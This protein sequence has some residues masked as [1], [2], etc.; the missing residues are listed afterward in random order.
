MVALTR[1]L[2]EAADQITILSGGKGKSHGATTEELVSYYAL[3]GISAEVLRFEA[4]KPG[5]ALLE[6]TR[7]VG[8][9]LLMM[10]AY[11]VSHERE[12]LF[13]GNTQAVVDHA[14]LP[15]VLAH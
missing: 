5:A 2:A 15:A 12:T 4:N 13:G 7:E 1:D 11:G 3:R 6:K 14:D 8:A 9:H 10:G